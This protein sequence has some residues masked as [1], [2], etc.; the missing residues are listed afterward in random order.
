MNQDQKYKLE[1]LVRCGLKNKWEG[2]FI[3]DLN[4]FAQSNPFYILTQSQDWWLSKLWF[5]HQK[6]LIRKGIIK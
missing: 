1:K 5:K 4:D 3:K 6:K 2:Q